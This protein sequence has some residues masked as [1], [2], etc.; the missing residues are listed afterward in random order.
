VSISLAAIR[1]LVS[2]IL[3]IELSFPYSSHDLGVFKTFM[4]DYYYFTIDG[5]S[6]PLGYV[7]NS[8]IRNVSWPTYWAIDSE[9]RILHLTCPH[10]PDSFERRTSL[11]DET[12]QQ[13]KNEGKIKELCWRGEPVELHTVEGVH[14]CNMNNLGTQ[15]FGTIAFGVHL[16]AW[17]RK[18]EATLY[19]LQRRSMAKPMHPGKLDTI[20]GGGL[21]VGEKAIDAMAREAAEEASIPVDFSLSHLKACGTVSYQLSYSFLNNPGSFPHV[22]YVYE[23]E[24]P[25]DFVPQPNDGEVDEFVTMT[26][27]QVME[28]LYQDDF[29]PIVGVQW[30][31]HF[32][33]HG[34]LTADNEPH[35]QE[36]CSRLHRKLD[37]FMV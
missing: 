8:I 34:I 23:M 13:A 14:I 20:A 1:P 16:I 24:L 25:E 33:R 10:T 3:I 35:L 37:T 15:M 30:V 2:I 29:K 7:H 19:W 5:F 27:S 28:A 36:L 32:Y 18:P 31:A 12:I 6:R 21:R 9:R 26:E 17:V 11:L 22:L 4:L